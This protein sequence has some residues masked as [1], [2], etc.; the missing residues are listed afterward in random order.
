MQPAFTVRTP[1][2]NLGV[3]VEQGC[4]AG[5]QAVANSLDLPP[6]TELDKKITRQLNQYCKQQTDCFD[7]SLKL[8]GTPFQK[9][10]WRE[11][12]RIPPGKVTTYGAIAEKLHTSP[13]AVGNACRRNPVLL[14]VPCHRVVSSS[15]LGGFAGKTRGKWPGIKRKLLQ[16]EGVILD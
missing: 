15:G 9:K 14:M 4:V 13:R 8:N 12:R 1:F 3:K 7:V 10:V 11:L 5:I 16:H 6:L 2:A